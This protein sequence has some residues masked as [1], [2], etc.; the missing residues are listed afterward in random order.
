MSI[1]RLRG[2]APAQ[3][4]VLLRGDLDWIV[5]RCLEKSR[6]RRYDTAS[7]LA[8]DIQRHLRNEPVEARPPSVLYLLQ[9]FIRRNR[10]GLGAVGMCAAALVAGVGLSRWQAARARGDMDQYLSRDPAMMLPSETAS[11]AASTAA[12]A[13]LSFKNL[14]AEKEYESFSDG[15]SEELRNVLAKVPSL[16]VAATTS[17]FFFKG[18]QVPVAEIGRTLGVNYVVD[19]SVRRSRDTVR[20]SAELINVS[21][22]FPLWSDQFDRDLK[23]IFALQEEIAREIAER[24]QLKLG[25]ERR[26][27][28]TVNPE[29]HRLVLEG[30]HH[31]NLRNE[32]GF[33]RAE[34]AFERALKLDP[35]FAEAHAGLAEVCVLRA[36]YR[37]FD[38]S[39]ETAD[40]LKRAKAEARRAIELDATIADPHA[41]LGF[42]AMLEGQLADSE[43]HFRKALALNPHSALIHCWYALLLANR[44]KLDA[45][46]AAYTRA[47]ALDP[48]WFINLHRQAWHLTRARRYAAALQVN[49]Q[50]ASLQ[51]DVHIPN[52][53]DQAV[54]LLGLGLTS[55]AVEAARLILQ[56]PDKEPRWQADSDAIWVLRQAGREKEAADHAAHLLEKWPAENYNR[57]FVLGALGRFEEALPYLE[58]T[59]VVPVRGLF[60][61]AM[62]DPFR[63]DPRFTQLLTKL[64]RLDDYRVARATL[65]RLINE[66]EP[67]RAQTPQPPPAAAK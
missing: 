2:T 50:A 48:L 12:I 64:G 63:D 38:G 67:T 37:Q 58:R 8:A 14:S 66:T 11:A 27:T 62:W 28:R 51:K 36:N 59:L 61:D 26:G 29:S 30:R 13:V 3:L 4:S 5:M 16:R 31:W 17:A 1:A 35:R 45:S 23:D 19:G 6:N 15:V 55:E 46:L 25:N 40:D 65:R 41:A 7:A 42:V 10:I 20:I 47:S 33:A 18:K 24:L 21:T 53:A 9:K 56:R 44:G 22:G 54:I 32:E 57:G 43:R 60:W 39:G 34:S 49:E 52:R